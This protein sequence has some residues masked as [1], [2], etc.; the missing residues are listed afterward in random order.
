MSGPGEGVR[1]RFPVFERQVYLNSCSQGALS[2]SVRAAYAAYLETL[3]SDGSLWGEWVDR[4]E[5]LRRAYARLL[6]TDPGAVAVTTSASAGAAA[7]ASALDFTGGRD[8]VVTTDLE[9]PTIGQVWHAQERRGARVVHVPAAE[10]NT[11]PLDRLAAAIDDRTAIVS[12]TH[13][14]Y[15]N[16]SLLD[17][18]AIA[19]LAH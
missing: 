4:A 16:G 8:T 11:L 3:E 19:E 2:D 15:R 1:Q 13:V 17:I 5:R 18:A 12:A 9:F 6:H 7:V 10:D 14:C